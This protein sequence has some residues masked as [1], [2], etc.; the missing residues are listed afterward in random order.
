MHPAPLNGEPPG[1][2]WIEESTMN[3]IAAQGDCWA[4]SNFDGF[5]ARDI[6][7]AFNIFSRTA[8]KSA[9]PTRVAVRS[10]DGSKF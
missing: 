5:P 7:P 3:Y 10:F 8:P 4:F 1:G 2:F 9:K 6:D